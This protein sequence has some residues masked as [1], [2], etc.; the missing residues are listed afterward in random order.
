LKS[1]WQ[2]RLPR[3]Y[4]GTHLTSRHLS[5]VIP[6]V[7]AKVSEAHQ[8]RPDMVLAAWPAIIGNELAEMAQAVSFSNGILR[9]RVNNST[10]LSLLSQRDKPKILAALRQKFPLL[11]IRNIV[12]CTG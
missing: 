4:N 2:Q 5:D 3:D 10:L 7:L 6:A 12:F 9:V 11:S 1:K 8:D